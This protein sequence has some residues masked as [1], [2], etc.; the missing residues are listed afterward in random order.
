MKRPIIEWAGCLIGIIFLNFCLPDVINGYTL[1]TINGMTDDEI[2]KTIEEDDIDGE[3]MLL[4]KEEYGRLQNESSGIR[5]QKMEDFVQKQLQEK[6][7]SEEW[8]NYYA[9]FCFWRGVPQKAY[10]CLKRICEEFDTP[11]ASSWFM[12][13]VLEQAFQNN[14]EKALQYARQA[15]ELAP[16]D[17][18]MLMLYGVLLEMDNKHAEALQYINQGI[19]IA[20]INWP[21]VC[22]YR[23][24][25]YMNLGEYA[26]AATDWENIINVRPQVA[27][28][29]Y[30][31]LIACYLYLN[32][33]NKAI[34]VLNQ[35]I[36]HKPD[37]TVLSLLLHLIQNQKDENPIPDNF[38]TPKIR[39]V[40][41]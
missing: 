3:Y 27:V 23:A 30:L 19:E 39:I 34:E 16:D 20:G 1:L 32:Q 36:R 26:K 18:Q 13:A 2:C 29:A 14:N 22:S 35:A 40:I 15:L 11:F 21:N 38:F 8:S 33:N 4:I 9:C 7:D 5:I 24:V 31:N 37:E 41:I 12:L 10:S 6:P 17:F 28:E 25:C